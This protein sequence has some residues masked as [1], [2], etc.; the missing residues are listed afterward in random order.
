MS[1][2]GDFCVLREIDS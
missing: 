1:F 2:S